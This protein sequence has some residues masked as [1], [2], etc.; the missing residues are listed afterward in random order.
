MYNHRNVDKS[1]LGQSVCVSLRLTESVCVSVSVCL[2]VGVFVSLSVYIKP[3]R[4]GPWPA[5]GPGFSITQRNWLFSRVNSTVQFQNSSQPNSATK[6]IMCSTFHPENSGS[7]C[8]IY[9]QKYSRLL[10]F[11]VCSQQKLK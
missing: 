5:S 3:V 10:Y 8:L 2:Y 1:G 4:Y 11:P 9:E 6:I 7:L